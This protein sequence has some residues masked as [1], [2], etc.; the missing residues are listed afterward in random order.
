MFKSKITPA[1][2][3]TALAI[4]VFGATPV[5]HAAGKLVLGKSSVGTAQLKK[6]AV[7]SAKVK[8][9]SLLA[10]DFKKDQLPAGPQGPNGDQGPKGD[11]GVAHLSVMNRQGPWTDVPAMSTLTAKAQC[12]PGE[13]ATGGGPV[14]LDPGLILLSS[15]AAEVPTPITWRVAVQN[16]TNA[17]HNFSVG[18]RLRRGMTAPRPA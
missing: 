10:V 8:N 13:V 16:T 11:S 15:N 6:N 7:T 17:T 14:G 4:A 18:G 5:G 12:Q 9:H 2:A 1:A 3:F